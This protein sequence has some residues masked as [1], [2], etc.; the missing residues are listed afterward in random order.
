MANKAMIIK[1]AVVAVLFGGAA[2]IGVYQYRKTTVL[3]PPPV[4]KVVLEPKT[5]A[6]GP[7]TEKLIGK[8]TSDALLSER[9]SQVVPTMPEVTDV[10]GTVVEKFRLRFNTVEEAADEA[11]PAGTRIVTS[12]VLTGENEIRLVVDVDLWKTPEGFDITRFA[13]AETRIPVDQLRMPP[14]TP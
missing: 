14:G 7:V 4:E 8:I 3:T 12:W 11:G 9:L 13:V 6:V 10:T 1:G 5:A 2:L